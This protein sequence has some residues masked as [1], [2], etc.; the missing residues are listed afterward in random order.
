MKKKL[1]FSLLGLMLLVLIPGVLWAGNQNDLAKDTP[2]ILVSLGQ[3]NTIPLDDAAI[4]SVRGQA[5]E[6]MLVKVFGLNMFDFGADGK[7]TWNPLGYRY[8]NWGG[9]GWTNKGP[10]VDPM[11][12][13][14]MLHDIG[15]P[16]GF[17]DRELLAALSSLPEL[18]GSNWGNWGKI[19]VTS[20][21]GVPSNVYVYGFSL[22]GGRIFPKPVEMPYTEYSRREAVYGMQLLILGKSILRIK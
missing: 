3:A 13:C 4:A 6:Y 10:Y 15:E 19:Y 5:P 21:E 12:F 16:T 1:F 9:P 17:T 20:P 11:D 2:A 8:G 14:F 18:Y 7:W 22:I